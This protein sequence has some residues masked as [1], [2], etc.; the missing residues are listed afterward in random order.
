MQE[1]GQRSVP[2]QSGVCC[3]EDGDGG[4]GLLESSARS[5]G[6]QLGLG[7]VKDGCSSHT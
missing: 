5:A 4:A 2:V 1:R 3:W 7:L 6:S